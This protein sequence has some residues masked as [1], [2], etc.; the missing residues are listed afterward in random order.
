MA[1]NELKKICWK[2]TKHPFLLEG[3]FRL[4]SIRITSLLIRVRISPDT[5]TFISFLVLIIAPVLVFLGPKAS[6][7][8]ALL[9]LVY[10]TLDMV[11]GELARYY[12]KK[13]LREKNIA[14]IYLDFICSLFVAPLLLG[15]L[16]IYY[17]I[18][19]DNIIILFLGL[20][21]VIASTGIPHYAKYYSLSEVLIRNTS[22]I[23]EQTILNL[24]GFYASRPHAGTNIKESFLRQ[25]IGYP[26]YF[27][28]F[29]VSAVLDL[30][31]HWELIIYG[32][33][34]YE[35]FKFIF[36]SFQILMRTFNMLFLFLSYYSKLRRVRS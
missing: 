6:A 12:S 8:S 17:Y 4:L 30:L 24:L 21:S 33:Q 31:Y 36:L 15:N 11:D 2:G 23:N 34:I 1:L 29:L 7:I 5:V 26:G 13:G 32:H 22:R 35:P 25:F 9:I 18:M 10:W 3:Y 14:G 27:F 16:A 19:L 20:L 28:Q